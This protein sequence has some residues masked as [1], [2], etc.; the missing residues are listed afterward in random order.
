MYRDT[1]DE[2][3]SCGIITEVNDTLSE[4]AQTYRLYCNGRCAHSDFKHKFYLKPAAF[5]NKMV[6]NP[7]TRANGRIKL[8]QVRMQLQKR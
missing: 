1:S 5:V 4:E 2:R 7:N 8:V 3:R 6:D